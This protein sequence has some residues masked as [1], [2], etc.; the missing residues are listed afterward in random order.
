MAAEMMPEEQ[1]DG[2]SLQT[3]SITLEQLEQLKASGSNIIY[4]VR[5]M[6]NRMLSRGCTYPHNALS[7][8]PTRQPVQ[9]KKCG[10]VCPREAWV[11]NSTNFVGVCK[12][13]QAEKERKLCRFFS[14]M[15][16]M[17]KKLKSCLPLL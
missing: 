10:V 17:A 5:L 2:D 14:R 1:G 6:C 7:C 8:T 12:E 9:L 16:V 3:I 4:V 13:L 11:Y 15:F